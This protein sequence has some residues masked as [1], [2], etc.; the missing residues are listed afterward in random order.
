MVSFVELICSEDLNR[1]KNSEF[2][3]VKK[4]EFPWL[5]ITLEFHSIYKLICVCFVWIDCIVG[6]ESAQKFGVGGG[7]EV[8]FPQ[9][10]RTNQTMFT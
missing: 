3:S 10:I 1:L 8:F 7:R 5:N 2:N 6:S 4:L 9:T